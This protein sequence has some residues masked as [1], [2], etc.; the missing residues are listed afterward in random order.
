MSIEEAWKMLKMPQK[1]SIL[2]LLLI[3]ILG[4]LDLL[5]DKKHSFFFV[6]IAD[7]QIGFSG[8]DVS[9]EKDSELFRKA[10]FSI[11]KLQPE[12]VV[13]CGDMINY[14]YPGKIRDLQV[15][16][17]FGILKEI[18][19]KIPVY[20]LPGN[21]E[22]TNSPKMQELNWYRKTF[23]KDYYKFKTNN[24]LFIVLN[25]NMI[26]SPK[27]INDESK[28]QKIWLKK[29]LS[30]SA[31]TSSGKVIVFQHHPFFLSKPLEADNYSNVPLACR[32]EYLD[33]LKKY[34]VKNVF[35]GHYHRC[36]DGNDGSLRMVTCG[37]VG[38]PLGK[39]QSGIM[40]V[41]ISEDGNIFHRF[42]PYKDIPQSVTLKTFK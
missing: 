14:P 41:Y 11:N 13:V 3:V 25:S 23:G 17:F 5:A 15:E 16:R 33:M 29:I 10:V 36:S 22:L 28:T 1:K 35:A 6:I 39:G 18:D 21:H 12:F 9:L 40:I 26:V 32:K 38:K 30:S 20:L 24:W 4:G 27:F 37:P 34:N 42:F 8:K 7:P 2:I 31:E 19:K